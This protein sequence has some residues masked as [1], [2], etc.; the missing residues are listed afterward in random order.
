MQTRDAVG[1]SLRNTSYRGF[2]LVQLQ[3]GPERPGS[4]VIIAV[5]VNH[6]HRPSLAGF[7]DGNGE[8]CAVQ[9]GGRS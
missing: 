7:Q 9:K 5:A 3:D 2:S 6:L 8:E 4:G 1:I